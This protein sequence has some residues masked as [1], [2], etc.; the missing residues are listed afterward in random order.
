MI[1]AGWC[2]L[3]LFAT[4]IGTKAPTGAE[5]LALV[6]PALGG[7]VMAL[8]AL[9]MRSRRPALLLASAGLVTVFAGIRTIIP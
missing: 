8:A 9:V 7:G 5:M 6:W 2:L 3:M 4:A 1:A